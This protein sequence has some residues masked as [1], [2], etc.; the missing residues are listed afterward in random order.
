MKNHGLIITGEKASNPSGG[1]GE[2]I[3]RGIAPSSYI[4]T[5]SLGLEISDLKMIT[6]RKKSRMKYLSKGV[7]LKY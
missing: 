5:S 7:D 1:N 3:S 4:A 6:R 2:H